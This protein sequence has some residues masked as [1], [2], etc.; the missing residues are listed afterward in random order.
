M[1]RRFKRVGGII[2]T[3][4]AIALIIGLLIPPLLPNVVIGDGRTPLGHLPQFLG[5]RAARERVAARR[6]LFA[7]LNQQPAPPAMRRQNLPVRS[8]GPP[9]KARRVG[10][11]ISAAFYV[12]WDDNSFV[13]LKAHASRLD[14]VI[15]EWGFVLPAGDSLRMRIDK[16]VLFLTQRL[17]PAERP[18]VLLMVTNYDS[19]R[20]IFDPIA[21]QRLVSSPAHRAAVIAQLAGAVHTYG[22]GGVTV[23]FEDVPGRENADVRAFLKELGAALHPTGGVVA[24]ALPA[25]MPAAALKQYAAVDDNIIL[26]LY[27]EHEGKRD[28]GPVAGQAWYAAEARRAAA[29]VPPGK[30]ILALGAYGYEWN[31]AD[32]NAAGA[33]QTFQDVMRLAHAHTA[34]V[35]FDTTSLNPYLSW[36]D[37]DSTDHVVWYLDGVTAFNELL[38]ANDV[39]AA[40]TAVWRLGAED[41]SIWSVLGKDGLTGHADSLR[42]MAVGYDVEFRGSGELL[43]IDARPTRGARELR[44]NPVT[45]VDCVRSGDR[46]SVAVHRWADR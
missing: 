10:D 32:P 13:S 1:V 3:V 33:E 5:T 11:P 35:R 16:R 14:W 30:L 46:G 27:D 9:P 37:P 23:D 21:L 26:M 17:P 42:A 4:L 44:T 41:P 40:G 39:G 15:C 45:G 38:V 6:R 18:A 43:R 20:A 25:G 22:L 29:A 34:R 28:V 19:A 8:P 36:T 2:T 7:A 24:Q 31:D 12:N